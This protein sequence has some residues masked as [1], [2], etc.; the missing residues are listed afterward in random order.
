M[1]SSISVRAEDMLEGA[2]NC[3]VLKLQIKNVLQEHD[4]E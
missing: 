4:H 1:E 3:N 2:S